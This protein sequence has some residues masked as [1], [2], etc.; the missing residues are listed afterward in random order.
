MLLLLF[1]FS[2]ILKE[3]RCQWQPSCYTAISFMELQDYK[4]KKN[5][6]LGKCRIVPVKLLFLFC[7][8]LF[9]LI[10]SSEA[11]D[12]IN[13]TVLNTKDGLSS[14]SV[15]TILKDKFGL[16]WFGTEDGLA[17]FDGNQFTIYR[18]KPGDAQSLQAN[19]IL[20]LHE[21]KSGN[22]W[23][24]TSGGSLSRYN[25]EKDAFVNF[26]ATGAANTI[27]NNVV[28]NLTSD[29][30]GNIWIGHYSGVNILDPV[31]GK[32][33]NLTVASGTTRSAFGMTTNYLLEDSKQQMWLGTND[34]LFLYNF[35]S[36]TLQHYLGEKNINTIAEDVKGNLWVGSNTGINFLPAGSNNFLSYSA[37]NPAAQS[38]NNQYINTIVANDKDVWIGSSS[39]LSIIRTGTDEIFKHSQDFR[40]VHSLTAN[41]IKCIYID[42]QGIYWL[43]TIGG[44]VNKYDKNLNL[45]NY[46]KS[47]VFDEKGLNASV[48]TAFAEGK[49]GS[50]YVG[51]QGGGLSLFDPNTKLFQHFNIRSKRAGAENQISILNLQ[52]N[53][54]NDLLIGTYADGMFIVNTSTGSYRQ[55]L[56]GPGEGDINS[57][58]IFCFRKLRNGH[59]WV[60]TNGGGINVLDND[61][62]VIKKYTPNPRLANEINLPING[63]IRDI[64]EDRNG[65]IWIATHGGGLAIFQASSEKF[66]IYNSFNSNLANNK[67][68]TLLE[69]SRGNIWAGTFGGG[70]CL[71]SKSTLQFTN[72]SEKEGLNNSTVYKILEDEN[73]L[74]WVST[75]KGISSIDAV[76]KKINNY[77]YHN[78]IQ[79]NNFYQ[80]AGL[81]LST[82]EL[83]FGGLEGFN[84]FN[85]E[86]LK[87]NNNVPA[88]LFTDLKVS[89]QPV[90]PSEDGPLSQHITVAKEIHLDYKQNF[91]IS[92]VGLNYT[93]PEQNQ[94]A[95]KLQGFDKGWNYVGTNNTA[96]YTNLDPGEYTFW[97]KASN[98]DGV[99]NDTGT[100]IKIY[101]RPPFWRTNFAYI[102]YFLLLLGFLYYLR[103]RNTRKIK[104]KVALAKEKIQLEQRHKEA[105]RNH[106]LDQLK[107]KFLTNLSHEFRTP[108]SLILG[109][110][111]NLLMVEKDE[112]TF[113]QLNMIKR[114]GK[115][116]LNLVNQILDFRKME[117]HELRLQP[118]EG[119]LISY[120]KEVSESFKDLSERKKIDFV[121]YSE[122]E[123]LHT[124]FDHDKIERIL[125]NL[126]SN[127]FKFT[128]EGGKISLEIE[129]QST[130][131]DTSK[132][133]VTIRINDTGIGIPHDKKEKI[134]ERFFQNTTATSILNQGTGIGLSITKEFIKMQGGTIEVESEPGK[135][136]TFS[137]HLPFVPIDAQNENNT[138]LNVVEVKEE[139]LQ[140]KDQPEIPVVLLVE[141]NEDFRLYLKENL[142]KYYKVLEAANGKEGWQ[143]ALAYHPQLIV[144]DISMPYM[145]GIEL[146]QKIKNDKRTSHIPVILLTAL[147]GEEDVLKGLETGANDYITKPFNYEV[148]NAKIKNLLTLNSTLKNTY[149]KQIKVLSPEVEIE[150]EDEKLLKNITV[151][152]EENLTNSQLSVEELSKHL[153][154]S[155][156]SLYSKLLQLT[157]QTPV[158]YI[159]SV[160]LEKAAVLLEKSDLNIAQIAYSVGFSTP[161]YF[162]KSFKAKYNLLPS[163]YMTKMRKENE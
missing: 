37:I 117:E 40:N 104:N 15:N 88:L 125:F 83:F 127:A 39:E 10:H 74:I 120:I 80:S 96:S 54:P 100:S 85:P 27:N 99:W 115:R 47:N 132:T 79:K 81:R 59:I 150:S 60:G 9:G 6:L 95:Y 30:S 5:A 148:L 159:R 89:N 101:V 82:G 155:R 50:V 55:L 90:S 64:I 35:K 91:A 56:K 65:N 110:V 72:F 1:I 112:R 154:M 7:L 23:I 21:D 97:V 46:V 130:H 113:Q 116:L 147:T 94:Y 118:S 156:S 106:E 42:D 17:R 107:I 157:G 144:S 44:G 102:F 131:T 38:L 31:T 52:M 161:N 122:I 162:A 86:N 49:N 14:N 24:G 70:V 134:F 111:D 103:K 63:Y 33:S 16:M 135:G 51:T 41:S 19:E 149:S 153:G 75:N 68:L 69:D 78:G 92:F 108:I 114:N 109:P 34:G 145:D 18:H 36:K 53:G 29:H 141:D 12:D 48:V 61:Y 71:F 136:S 8:C 146:T 45:F 126:L 151:Y 152:L 62:R 160:K 77:N 57:N 128:Y 22:L 158:E 13:F 84:Y 73:G 66:I 124:Q 140:R 11:Q 4:L 93:A 143:K 67:V 139:V 138:P 58:Y 98:N 123:Q 129:K 28:L 20:A 105:E 121:F 76:T 142:Q 26:P 3:N 25:R 133:W 43:G 2:T 32:I 119:E 87:K 163:E 137:I